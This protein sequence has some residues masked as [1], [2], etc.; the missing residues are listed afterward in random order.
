MIKDQ[1]FKRLL[2][3]LLGILIPLSAGL[4]TFE[5]YSVLQLVVSNIFFVF[6]SFVIWEG[7]IR[8]ISVLR[9]RRLLQRKIFLKLI[10]L[11]LAT[12]LYSILVIVLCSLTWQWVMLETFVPAPVIRSAVICAVT[13]IVLTL[14]YE[15]IFLNTERELDNRI[16]EQLDQERVRAE[17]QV[18]KNELDPHFLFNCLNTLMHLVQHEPEKS[19]QFI[20]KLSKVYKYFLLNKEKDLVPLEEEIDFLNNYYYLLKIRFDD[21]VQ[22]ENRIEPCQQQLLILPCALQILVENAIK[23]N[24]FS[25]KA[26]L[27]ITITANEWFVMVT[28]AVKPKMHA[29]DST[30]TGL[31]NLVT[32]YRLMLNKPVIIQS[33]QT[34]FLVKLP[35]VK[36]KMVS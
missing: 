26:P 22:I 15:S 13:V 7:N 24:F 21:H 28:N 9:Y 5:E 19:V 12:A 27:V 33:T 18:L 10:V 23:H 6:T 11:S 32:R 8:I 1:V 16:L 3:P 17:V 4:I 25:E 36:E 29:V 31:K 2:I 30:H 34:R 20:S 35:I 14:V